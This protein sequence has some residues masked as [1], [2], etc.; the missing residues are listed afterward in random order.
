MSKKK[1]TWL[2]FNVLYWLYMDWKVDEWRVLL[3]ENIDQFIRETRVFSQE[4]WFYTIDD[5]RQ[6]MFMD[7]DRWIH[8]SV[9]KNK[10]AKQA[11]SY[12]RTR[13]RWIMLNRANNYKRLSDKVVSLSDHDLE[14]LEWEWIEDI[15]VY[16]LPAM[17]DALMWLPDRQQTI[18]LLRYFS[19]KTFSIQEIAEYLDLSITSISVEHRIALENL[20]NYYFTSHTIDETDICT[21]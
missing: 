6:D 1:F 19:D 5:I 2:D 10:L 3:Y 7:I 4:D 17:V 21:S 18:I 9:A 8:N 11:Y 12:I 14:D 15:M 16:W 13:A 20:K